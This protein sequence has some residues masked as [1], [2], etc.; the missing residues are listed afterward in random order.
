MRSAQLARHERTSVSDRRIDEE[1]YLWYRVSVPSLNDNH[2]VCDCIAGGL[3]G[4]IGRRRSQQ[5]AAAVKSIRNQSVVVGDSWH[6]LTRSDL[7]PCNCTMVFVHKSARI[8]ERPKRNAVL[9]LANL[10]SLIQRLWSYDR[11]RTVLEKLLLITSMFSGVR[12]GHHAEMASIILV[13]PI[14]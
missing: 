5:M 7:T 8:N 11:T 6:Y 10:R 9:H 14:H 1:D 3:N 12:T 13:C 2:Y 4:L